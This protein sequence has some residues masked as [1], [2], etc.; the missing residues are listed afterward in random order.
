M[1]PEKARETILKTIDE[2]QDYF[3]TVSLSDVKERIKDGW[4]VVQAK[5]ETYSLFR[6]TVQ[7][8]M[9]LFTLARPKGE[10]FDEGE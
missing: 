2:S 4:V 7:S 6:E 10:I 5:E 9:Y 1:T 8:G 3:W